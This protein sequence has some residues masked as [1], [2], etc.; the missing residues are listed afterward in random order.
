[1]DTARRV[2]HWV[3][4]VALL[5]AL[6]SVGA[7]RAVAQGAAADAPAAGANSAGE[8]YDVA[9]RWEREQAAR[10]QGTDQLLFG[11]RVARDDVKAALDALRRELATA[12]DAGARRDVESRI[13][14]C[15]A[16]LNE[17]RATQARELEDRTRESQ[18]LAEGFAAERQRALDSARVQLDDRQMAAQEAR[19]G[20]H[21]RLQ[22]AERN[23]AD[24]E[25]QRAAGAAQLAAAEQAML[26][27]RQSAA[28]DLA[29]RI[30]V[31]QDPV[32]DLS[33][34]A[35]ATTYQDDRVR[36]EARIQAIQREVASLR[37]SAEL[38]QARLDAADRQDQAARAAAVAALAER[39][40]AARREASLA[41]ADLDAADRALQL[42]RSDATRFAAS[43]TA[44]R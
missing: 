40:A 14:A 26:S 23:L 11:Q 13:A 39:A 4:A 20:A 12:R 7:A 27:R 38:D 22:T 41:Q 6:S 19:D 3:L 29:G 15:V 8:L 34:R 44:R 28:A 2:G 5:G 16:S 21:E 35:Q 37:E 42:A 36:L 9:P 33:Q 30:S 25:A 10:K 32:A 18:I 24:L 43:T 1:M 17:L 31:A